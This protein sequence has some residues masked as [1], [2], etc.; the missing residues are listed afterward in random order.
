[1][2]IQEI[3]D[4][5]FK[6]KPDL[7]I[8]SIKTYSNCLFK[9]L[10]LLDTKDINILSTNSKK[11]IE[12]I[13]KKWDNPNT[14]KTKFASIIVILKILPIDKKNK[15]QLINALHDYSQEIEKS[16]IKINNDLKESTKSDDEK[17][18]WVS[19]D[20]MKNLIEIYKS[21]VPKE[22]K[23]TLDL[24]KFRNYIILL[25][26]D[27]LASRAELADSKIIYSTS[28]DIDD[29]YNYIILDKKNKKVSYLMNQYKT[30]KS[31]GAKKIELDNNL[32]DVMNKY[33]KAVDNF[34]D[35]NYLLLNDNG[36]DKLSRNRLGVIYKS[37]GEP[38]NKKL[39]IMLNRH[40]KVSDLIPIEK[41][42]KMA[43]DMGHSPEEALKV[44]AKQ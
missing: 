12:A 5:I 23:T 25:F 40:I 32:Y 17:K 21:N 35:K 26:Y 39:G 22:I 8:M 10:Q 2:D 36:N 27:S 6:A 11:V 41:I 24:K 14:K 30:V 44:Y 7:S 13:N 1:M 9:I 15:K 38:I 19:K 34:N 33:K 42:K 29:E 3:Q 43:S 20:E 37:L 18:N 31:Y 16:S 4:L 28:K